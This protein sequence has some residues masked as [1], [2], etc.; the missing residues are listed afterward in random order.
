[1]TPTITRRHRL[2][3]LGATLLALLVPLFLAVPTDLRQDPLIG[4]VA[5]RYHVVLFLV[6][7]ILL[8]RQGPL[9]GRFWRVIAACLILGGA[10]ELLQILAG[11]SATVFDWYQDALGVALGACWIWWF[12]RRQWLGPLG[13]AVVVVA[14]ILW[15]MRL[16]PVT[17]VEARAVQASFPQLA[18][19]ERPRSVALWRAT[20]GGEIVRAADAARGGVLRMTVES[21]YKWPGVRSRELPWDW[22]GQTKLRITCRLRDPSPPTMHLSVVLEDRG[23]PRDLDYAIKGFAIDH[24]WQTLEVDLTSLRTRRRDRP[25]ALDNLHTLGIYLVRE[26]A[27]PLVLEVDTIELAGS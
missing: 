22:T 15:P 25:L 6:L 19:F 9:A 13:V 17:V 24:A 14:L 23:G 4:P 18:S 21:D 2:P 3:L 10:T 26:A 11:R 20:G 1:M 7:T 5:D 12:R 16:L 27:G 8:Y